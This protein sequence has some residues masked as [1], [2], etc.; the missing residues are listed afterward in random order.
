MFG[1]PRELTVLRRFRDGYMRSLPDGAA[2][3]RDYYQYAPEVV[4][5][6]AK[7]D[8]GNEEWPQVYAMVQTAIRHIESGREAEALAVYAAEYL[9]LKARY[10]Q[11][12]DQIVAAR[13][14]RTII[15]S[16]CCSSRFEQRRA[17]KRHQRPS[18]RRSAEAILF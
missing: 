13:A 11:N 3:I 14:A 10:V 15:G 12:A 17:H 8:K 1:I 2:M 16:R 18:A 6:I 5:S 9:R 4:E 7:N